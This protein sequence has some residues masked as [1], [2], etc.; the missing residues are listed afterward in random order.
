MLNKLTNKEE[1]LLLSIPIENCYQLQANANEFLNHFKVVQERL[2]NASSE[3]INDNDEFDTDFENTA[4]MI[5]SRIFLPNQREFEHGTFSKFEYICRILISVLISI[6]Y[7]VVLYLEISENADFKEELLNFTNSTIRIALN[8]LT[9]L[10]Y[11][12]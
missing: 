3:T 11:H 9:A 6:I 5:D 4:L 1:Q 7:F 10:N 8:G 12:K 2:Q